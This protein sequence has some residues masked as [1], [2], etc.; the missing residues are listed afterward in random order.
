MSS[1][2]LVCRKV[3]YRF[4]CYLYLHFFLL[5]VVFLIKHFQDHMA[6]RCWFGISRVGDLHQKSEGHLLPHVSY[7]CIYVS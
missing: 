3:R 7:T 2:D 6:G 5:V 1:L 4:F